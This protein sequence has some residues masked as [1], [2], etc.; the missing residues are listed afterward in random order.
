[1]IAAHP[2]RPISKQWFIN[3]ELSHFITQKTIRDNMN[4]SEGYIG[5]I[6]IQMNLKRGTERLVRLMRLPISV[7]NDR[8]WFL[9]SYNKK[10]WGNEY[11]LILVS[12]LFINIQNRRLHSTKIYSNASVKWIMRAWKE[13]HREP[14]ELGETAN[15]RRQWSQVIIAKLNND[16]K[17]KIIFHIS[18]LEQTINE[19]SSIEW[20][21]WGKIHRTE[22]DWWGCQLK[23]AMIAADS[24]TAT[25]NNWESKSTLTFHQ[26]A[27]QAPIWP[28]HTL[29]QWMKLVTN[30]KRKAHWTDSDCWD[31]Q[32]KRAIIAAHSHEP[33]DND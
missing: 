9:S 24:V 20:A 27:K 13:G 12:H 11:I 15:F 28:I 2:H 33:G 4:F 5:E 31:C 30:L 1:M 19:R 8:S 16:W 22:W 18:S 6:N 17:S 23:R 25:D 32:L 29:Q 14:T 21:I 3:K 7:G 26:T 10:N